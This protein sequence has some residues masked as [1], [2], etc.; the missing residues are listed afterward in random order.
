[1]KVLV[2]VNK[3]KDTNSSWLGNLENILSNKGIAYKVITIK[4]I[5]STESADA[6]IVLGGDGTILGLNEFSNKNDIPIIGIN[7]GKLGFLTEFEKFE[8]AFAIDCLINN[9]LIKDNRSTMQIDFNGKTYCALNDIVVQRLFSEDRNTVINV[10][11]LVGESPVENIVGDGVIVCTPTGSTAYSLSAGGAILA[12]GIN[13]FSVT[14]ISAHSLSHRPIIYSADQNCSITL[15]GGEKA[16]V[17]YDGKFL[18]YMQ[19]GDSLQVKKYDKQTC[20]LRK[21]DS[22]FFKLL[23][24]KMLGQNGVKNG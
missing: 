4:D 1:M 15:K 17:F 24:N 20:F 3:E 10:E 8:T 21:K 6:L 2:Y 18:G 12:P 5:N 7:A 16:S 22:N 23:R 13:A 14:P 19:Q 11:V 9:Q